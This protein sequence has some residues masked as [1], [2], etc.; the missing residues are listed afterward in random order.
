MSQGLF[1]FSWLKRTE[2]LS[3]LLFRWGGHSASTWTEFVARRSG[4]KDGRLAFRQRK[5]REFNET[6]WCRSRK[7]KQLFP[8]FKFCDQK[9]L[10]F[11][12]FLMCIFR[13][14]NMG[15]ISHVSLAKKK[16]CHKGNQY[17]AC[18][19]SPPGWFVGSENMCPKDQDL[20]SWKLSYPLPRHFDDDF[21]FPKMGYVTLPGTWTLERK[22]RNRA[23]SLKTTSSTVQPYPLPFFDNDLKINVTSDVSLVFGPPLL[24]CEDLKPI[25]VGLH[26]NSR[27][28]LFLGFAAIMGGG[29]YVNPSWE[30]HTKPEL[31]NWQKRRLTETSVSFWFMSFWKVAIGCCL[32]SS[33]VSRCSCILEQT[34][35]EIDDSKDSHILHKWFFKW[36]R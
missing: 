33:C 26:L 31:E 29:V 18:P 25:S 20:P 32:F 5:N 2:T 14:W 24:R 19:F 15:S 16:R 1:F 9:I 27:H 22:P 17:D 8:P 4:Q 6:S 10:W 23:G 7:R 36:F 12:W 30:K 13:V 34:Y 11:F 35:P 28:L 3:Y 21:P